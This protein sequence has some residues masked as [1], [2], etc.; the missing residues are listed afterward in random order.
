MHTV[1]ASGMSGADHVLL[2]IVEEGRR[3][4]GTQTFTDCF[5]LRT[6][7][8]LVKSTGPGED[9]SGGSVA[10]GRRLEAILVR[11]SLQ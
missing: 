4:N 1:R 8:R 9:I 11:I 6:G 10:S 7:K 5:S 3:N 2:E